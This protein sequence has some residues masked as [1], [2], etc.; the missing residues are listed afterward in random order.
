VI[1]DGMVQAGIAAAGLLVVAVADCGAELTVPTTVGDTAQ[2]LD[3]DMHQITGQG[4]L[5]ALRGG[6]RTGRPVFWSR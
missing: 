1:V 6:R 3:I 5:I 4:V 2:F